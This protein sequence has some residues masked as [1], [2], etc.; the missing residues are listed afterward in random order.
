MRRRT[1]TLWLAISLATVFLALS[2][3]NS[4][5]VPIPPPEAWYIISPNEDGYAVV[6]GEPGAADPG[7]VAVVH[8]KNSDEYAA[9][10]VESDG[11]FE[12][13]IIAE[14]GDKIVLHI[15]HDSKYSD[16]S[17]EKEVPSD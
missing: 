16:E 1:F 6:I 9:E 17:D 12:V 8:N 7:D 13:E 4:P 14:V 2:C 15:I 5:T 10:G 3:N 11:S